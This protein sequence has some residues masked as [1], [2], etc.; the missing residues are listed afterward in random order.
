VNPATADRLIELNRQF[1]ETHGRDFSNTRQRLQPGVQRVL[2]SFR[3]D[4]SILDLGCGNGG[5][6]RA[7]SRRGHR[8]A[9]LGLDFSPPMLAEA[10]REGFAFP[11]QF[12]R[13]DLLMLSK[14][15]QPDR[16]QV[17]RSAAPPFSQPIGDRLPVAG[18]WS[19]VTAFAVL[20]HIPGHENRV[21]LLSKVHEWLQAAGKFIHS[22]WQFLGSERLKARVQPWSAVGLTSNDVDPNDYLLDWRRGGVGLRYVHQLD[23]PELVELAAAGGFRIAD[24]FYSDGVD[25]RSGLYQI[26]VKDR[27]VPA[28]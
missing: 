25:G 15:P 27:S 20:H 5:L 22:N 23:E 7:L 3:G 1:Y 10:Q 14:Q 19:C 11:A 21:A 9:Y 28:G 4:E 16:I 17:I 2:R 24:G 13:V 18:S 6:A 26:W 12:A 8:G